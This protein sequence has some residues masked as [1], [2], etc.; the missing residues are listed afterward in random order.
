MVT[1]HGPFIYKLCLNYSIHLTFLLKPVVFKKE[2]FSHYLNNM[3]W[4]VF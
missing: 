1:V 4:S 2:S 3:K